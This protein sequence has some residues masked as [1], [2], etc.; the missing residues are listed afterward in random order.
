MTFFQNLA[1]AA[2]ALVLGTAI[3]LTSPAL[4]AAPADDEKAQTVVHMLDYVSVDYPEF[5]KDGK[6]LNPSEYDEQKEF[7][8]Q[9]IALL[10]QLPD[11]PEKAATLD[12]ARKLLASID[13][14]ADGAQVSA[15]AVGV[16]ADVIRIYKLTVAPK[17]APDLA[18]GARL[19]A[20]NCAA[21]HG[22]TGKGDGPLAK[23]MDPEPSNFHEED[24]MKQRSIY[25]LYNTIALGVKGTP[26][27]AW[28]ELPE[29]DRWALAFFVSA[30]RTPPAALAQGEA[31]WKEGKGKADIGSYKSLVT[32]A[33]VELAAKSP[34]LDPVRAY[35]TAHPEAIQAAA[36]APLDFTRTKL[37]EALVAYRAGNKDLA[38][39]LSITS[40]LEGFELVE[41]SLDNVD[42]PLRNGIEKEMMA[43]RALIGDGKPV[44]EVEAQVSKINALLGQAEEKL[45]G[46]GLSPATAFVS[47]LLILLREGL[48]AIL[49]LAA[50]TAF[51][52]KTG[53]QDA[54]PWV[55]AGWIAAVALGALTWV[56]ATYVIGISGANREL[57]EGITALVASAMLLYVG[58]WL[59][60][61][62]YAQAWNTFIKDQV[63]AALGK[64]TVWAM[65]GVSF[66][67]VYRELFEIVLF[68]Q[69]LWVQAGPESQHAVL[70][71]IAAAAVLLAII[72]G[73]ILKFSVRLPIGPFFAWTSGLLALMAVVFA[74]N[75]IAAL[76]EA[77]VVNATAVN[78]IS[79]PLLGI[80]PTAQGLGAQ[81]IALAIVLSGMY[82]SKRQAAA[83][84]PARP[85]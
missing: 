59:H 38:R 75:G 44:P 13:A 1:S 5:V 68:Y 24:R 53:R 54:M 37:D 41:A 30:M 39:Q 58:Y 16:R 82:L 11:A 69:T 47:S 49:V 73:A 27:R 63:S 42:A 7:A 31:L 50:I 64:G 36:P 22:V 3:S 34:E 45:G 65:A 20:A 84:A 17:T 52:K 28:T 74:G 19:F 71:G 8:T 46:G 57:T 40:Y 4:H 21:C 29:A 43:V 15:A 70:W 62:S 14:K 55:H 2:A 35:L 66:L 12:K 33:P 26:M 18:N 9:A 10:G 81:F 61:K 51:V 67:A 6:V 80:H 72:G 78:F 76:Q 25:G 79:V 85:A 60:S 32:V 77:G 83:A 48:E 56:V 23:G